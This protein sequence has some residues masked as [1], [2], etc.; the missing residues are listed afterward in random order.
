MTTSPIIVYKPQ[1]IT[2]LQAIEKLKATYPEYAHETLSYAGRLD[3]LAEGLLLILYG[4]QN[5]ERKAYES[6]E[7]TYEFTLLCGVSTDTYDLLG[8]ITAEAQAIPP[9]KHLESSL[10]EITSTLPSSFLQ[11]YPPYSSKPVLGKPLFW[12]AR[13]G[14][15]SEITRP[16]RRVSVTSLTYSALSTIE[17]DA[18]KKAVHD[19]ISRVTGDFRQE[20]I[21]SCWNQFFTT[22][23]LSHFPVCSFQIICSSGTYIRGLCQQFGEQLGIPS[24]AYSIRRTAIGSYTLKDS[25]TLV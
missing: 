21:L 20:E 22:T 13:E 23:P 7:K 12:W 25:I 2:P 16:T 3:P 4:E 18:L 24:L 5:K 1:G 14:R 9:L 10:A 11:T 19:T 17:K 8:K 6:V 15:L